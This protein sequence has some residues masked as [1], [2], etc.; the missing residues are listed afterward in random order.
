MTPNPRPIR[1]SFMKNWFAIE[2]IPIYA[3]IGTVVCGATWYTYRLAMGPSVVWTKSNPTPWNSIE[4]DQNT[5]MLT[6]N[7]K[8]ERRSVVLQ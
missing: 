3:I 4:P 6:V 5:K 1:S 7:Q 2:A 8:F